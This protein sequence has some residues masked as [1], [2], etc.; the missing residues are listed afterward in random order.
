MRVQFLCIHQLIEFEHRSNPNS[1]NKKGIPLTWCG[2]LPRKFARKFCVRFSLNQS[3][4]NTKTNTA[5]YIYVAQI[6]LTVTVFGGAERCSARQILSC[7]LHLKA[8]RGEKCWDGW[9]SVEPFRGSLKRPF[10]IHEIYRFFFG[11]GH[12]IFGRD[13][14]ATIPGD[15]SFFWILTSSGQLFCLKKRSWMMAFED[16][17][18]WFSWDCLDVFFVNI[19]L[20]D[21]FLRDSFFFGNGPIEFRKVVNCHA[22]WE[23]WAFID[24]RLVSNVWLYG[25]F[26]PRVDP[27]HLK[28]AWLKDHGCLQLGFQAFGC[29]RF[30]TVPHRCFL[31][32]E[33]FFTDV[34]DRCTQKTIPETHKLPSVLGPIC[35]K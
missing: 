30:W 12:A 13:F 33:S 14:E 22:C 34:W 21:H 3:W 28:G 24:I 27:K 8:A 20:W 7:S 23:I 25:Y 35:S 15:D 18:R 19:K 9:S 1:S 4:Q 6:S 32:P 5:E 26:P 11:K 17:H 29:F 2:F 31:G 16:V 10:K